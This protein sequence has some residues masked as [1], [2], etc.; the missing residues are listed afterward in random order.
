MK[1]TQL[2]VVKEENYDAIHA[3][4]STREQAEAYMHRFPDMGNDLLIIEEFELDPK[5]TSYPDKSPYTVKLDL[6]NE[7]MDV[8]T[9]PYDHDQTLTESILWCTEDIAEI[10]VVAASA[11]E[12]QRKAINVKQELIQKGEWKSERSL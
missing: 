10:T 6:N 8:Y 2:F 9:N 12:A 7:I 3:I 11:E 4:F 1:K 5:Y